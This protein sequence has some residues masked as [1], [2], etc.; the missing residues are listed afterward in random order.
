MAVLLQTVQYVDVLKMTLSA[1]EKVSKK[2]SH[3]HQVLSENTFEII[4]RLMKHHHK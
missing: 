3:H 1:G 4:C 2:V